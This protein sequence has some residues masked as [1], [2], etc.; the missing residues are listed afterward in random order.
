[1]TNILEV[2]FVEFEYQ[3]KIS[4]LWMRVRA[5]VDNAVLVH[6]QTHLDPEEWGPAI[7]E[8][9]LTIDDY[10]SDLVLNEEN[11]IEILD[12]SGCT[13]KLYETDYYW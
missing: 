11:I 13:W 6:Q 8:T 7:C 5:L 2:H 3:P 10:E 1:M 4:G 9:D 12:N